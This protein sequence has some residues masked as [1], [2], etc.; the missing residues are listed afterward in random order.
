MRAGCIFV[1]YNSKFQY[2][3]LKIESWPHHDHI[4]ESL[5]ESKQGGV[6]MSQILRHKPVVPQ[7]QTYWPDTVRESI[8]EREEESIL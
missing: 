7:N 3:C 8:K 4:L 5:E 1:F 2:L 6:R